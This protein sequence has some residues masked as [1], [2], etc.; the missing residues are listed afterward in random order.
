MSGRT[1][2]PRERQD[3]IHRLIRSKR[4]ASVREL[5][6]TTNVSS[7]TIRRDLEALEA[8]GAV[9]RVFGG[10]QVTEPPVPEQMYGERMGQNRRAKERIAARAARLV[11]DGDTVAL[12]GSTSAVYL[13]RE[14]R[15]RAVAVV[16]NSLLAAN[17]L[18][19][20]AA[21]VFLP[22]GTLR[23]ATHTLAGETAQRTLASVNADKVFFSVSGLHPD[24]GWSDSNAEE[25]AIKRALFS[26]AATRIALVDASKFGRSSLHALIAMEDVHVLISDEPPE[27]RL[28]E[29]LWRAEVEVCLADG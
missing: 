7:M 26:I 20:G 1:L 5:A 2:L 6:S 23:A 18:A 3:V 12:D 17:E 28:A 11:Q 9:T 10:A 16:T 21:S 13:A 25:V 19:G 8:A 24:V 14:L 4:Y 29:A 27:V 15:H 22:G